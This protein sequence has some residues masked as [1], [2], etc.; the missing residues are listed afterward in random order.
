[1]PADLAFIGGASKDTI[2][3][4]GNWSCTEKPVTPKDEIDNA[5]T[6]LFQAPVTVNG[7]PDG[8]HILLY[9]AIERGIVNGTSNAGFWIFQANPHC[10]VPAGA[11]GA[12]LLAATRTGTSWCSPPSTVAARR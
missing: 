8:I 7:S 10:V 11:T 1:M 9:S 12:P 5:Y 3:P 4:N 2:D 6:A